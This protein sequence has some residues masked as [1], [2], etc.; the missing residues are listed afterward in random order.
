M[1]GN[2][3]SLQSCR[4]PPEHQLQ[5]LEPGVSERFAGSDKDGI[6][7]LTSLVRWA[8][9]LLLQGEM[10]QLRI[11]AY[12]K[13]PVL[14]G[15]HLEEELLLACRHAKSPW[16]RDSACMG[17]SCFPASSTHVCQRIWRVATV[18]KLIKPNLRWVSNVAGLPRNARSN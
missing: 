6:V 7:W 11:Y 14:R 15:T 1:G 8:L 3:I 16:E 13:L 10:F 12:P 9:L 4:F 17:S 5:W 18:L 2:S